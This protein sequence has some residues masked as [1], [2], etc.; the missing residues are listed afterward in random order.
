MH[1]GFGVKNTRIW[2]GELR[3]KREILGWEKGFGD[4]QR[5]WAGKK[6]I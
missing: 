4:P 3:W 6:I 2:G 1:K 5:I